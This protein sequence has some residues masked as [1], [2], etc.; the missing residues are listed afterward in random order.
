MQVVRCS[1]L[2]SG[3]T[4]GEVVGFSSTAMMVIARYRRGFNRAGLAYIVWAASELA[5]SVF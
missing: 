3:R 5:V 2:R 1:L 4:W